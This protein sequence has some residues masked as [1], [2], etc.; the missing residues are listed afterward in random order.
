[1]REQEGACLFDS[2]PSRQLMFYSSVLNSAD[3]MKS[4]LT[5]ANAFRSR[6][7]SPSRV[8]LAGERESVRQIVTS[9]QAKAKAERTFILKPILFDNGQQI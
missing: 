4:T 3:T 1:M 5:Q 6:F 9:Q 2:P 8:I 7:S